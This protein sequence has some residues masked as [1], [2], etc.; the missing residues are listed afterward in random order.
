MCAYINK[1]IIKS[2]NN[3][4]LAKYKNLK[5]ISLLQLRVMLY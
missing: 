5:Y 3:M 1:V 4:S 2:N